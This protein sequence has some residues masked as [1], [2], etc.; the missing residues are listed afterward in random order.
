MIEAIK[1]IEVIKNIPE[2]VYDFLYRTDQRFKDLII[3]LEYAKAI[4]D[5]DKKDVVL[6]TIH[7]EYG[8]EFI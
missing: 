2:S 4:E 3:Q 8:K 1:K 7:S 6:Q 5:D